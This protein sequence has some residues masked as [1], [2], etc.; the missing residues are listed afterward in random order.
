VVGG[1][2]REA[3]AASLVPFAR[4]PAA[5]EVEVEAS[6]IQP[7]A[8]AGGEE[9]QLVRVVRDQG[10]LRVPGLAVYGQLDPARASGEEPQGPELREGLSAPLVPLAAVYELG[11]E[12]ERDVVQEES[13]GDAPD[14]DP[15]LR[16]FEGVERLD[17]VI[18][19]E[20]EVAREVVA[21]AEWDADERQVALECNLR[22]RRERAVAA[23][24]PEDLLVCSA[25]APFSIVVGSENA[26]RQTTATR[27]LGKLL[28]RRPPAPRTGIDE[29]EAAQK[30]F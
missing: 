1:V 27:L 6:L 14:V 13:V 26:G 17:G 8:L 4:P 18:A 20:P 24:N 19:V 2:D 25:G 5:R 7:S 28:G 30:R 23:G 10:D 9:L 21:G 12:A 3:I 11:I 15:P 16:T 29:E 22:Y